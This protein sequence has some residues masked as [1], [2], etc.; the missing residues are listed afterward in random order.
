MGYQGLVLLNTRQAGE[1][2]TFKELMLQ[3]EKGHFTMES[4]IKILPAK[5]EQEVRSKS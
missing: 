2:L 5:S 1:P 4:R 3:L